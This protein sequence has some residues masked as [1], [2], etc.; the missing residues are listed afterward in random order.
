MLQGAQR[1][2]LG[3]SLLALA[4]V[5]SNEGLVTFGVGVGQPAVVLEEQ[6][7][8]A[9]E[10]LNV[11]PAVLA[12]DVGAIARGAEAPYALAVRGVEHLNGADSGVQVVLCKVQNDS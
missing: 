3:G 2:F 7:L 11:L 6:L 8:P 9:G 10:G 1:S 5:A 12:G 4:R